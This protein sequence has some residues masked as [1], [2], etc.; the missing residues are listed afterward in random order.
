MLLIL[1]NRVSNSRFFPL[2]FKE[3]NQIIRDKNLLIF[4]LF[5]PI[6]QL[7]IF[8]YSINPDIQKLKLGVVN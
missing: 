1:F 8:G 3:I 6:I 2:F 4:L 7:L 5:S